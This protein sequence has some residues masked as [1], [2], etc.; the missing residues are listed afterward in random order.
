M[1]QRDEAL[2][3]RGIVIKIVAMNQPPHSQRHQR[4]RQDNG[5]D[6]DH[7]AAGPGMFHALAERG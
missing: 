2:G 6:V 5:E 3:Q 4:V 7:M 1:H